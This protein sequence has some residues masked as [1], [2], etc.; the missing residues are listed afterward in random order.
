MRDR[1]SAKVWGAAE[2][3]PGGTRISSMSEPS[4]DEHKFNKVL[5]HPNDISLQALYSQTL[6][7]QILLDSPKII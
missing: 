4:E 2:H 3:M 5:L 6:S 7:L 1:V